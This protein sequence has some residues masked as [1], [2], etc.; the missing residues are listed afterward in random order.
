MVVEKIIDFLFFVV[1]RLLSLL[2]S[3]SNLARLQSKWSSFST[4]WGYVQMVAYLL[5]LSTIVSIVA[6][7]ITI[8]L[9]RLAVSVI[10]TVW[11]LLPFV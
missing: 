11:D 8:S 2:P 10:R 7:V 5:P 6:L 1:K 3:V 9:F 4:F